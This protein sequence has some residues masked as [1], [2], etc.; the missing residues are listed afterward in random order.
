MKPGETHLDL[1]PIHKRI[2]VD[3]VGSYNFSGCRQDR[4]TPSQYL[5]AMDAMFKEAVYAGLEDIRV[6]YRYREGDENNLPIMYVGATGIRLE[7]QQ[8]F[9]GRLEHNLRGRKSADAKYLQDKKIMESEHRLAA[10]RELEQAIEAAKDVLEHE[11][12]SDKIIK[13][14]KQIEDLSK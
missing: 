11:K 5:K 12:R 6:E 7:T 14:T 8:E 2:T 3:G 4:W 1:V 10:T 13:L 9:L